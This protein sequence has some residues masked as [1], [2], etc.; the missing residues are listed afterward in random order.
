MGCGASA[1][2][3][4]DHEASDH[5]EL[6]QGTGPITTTPGAP[7]SLSLP[8]TVA[9]AGGI[10]KWNSSNEDL[11]NLTSMLWS[12]CKAKTP[13]EGL[14]EVKAIMSLGHNLWAY[15]YMRM[16]YAKNPEVYYGT[17]LK[18]P[19]LLLPVVYTPTVGEA[20]QKFGKLP[21]QRRGCYV[22]LKDRGNV[23]KVVEEY[24]ASEL[25]KGPDG[26]YMCDC[27]V[28]SDGGR[29][30]GLGDL[31]AW[32][33]GIPIGKLDL[34][35]VC[36]GVNPYRT[37]PVIL[38]AG[39]SDASGNTDKLVIREDP[40]YTGMKQDRVKH[41]SEAKTQVNTA[42]YDNSFVT[43]FMQACCDV[44]GERVLLQFED[45][46]SNDAFP[47]LASHRDKFLTYNDDIQ[48]TAAVA[49]AGLLGGIKLQN[50]SCTD[51]IAEL[52]KKTFLFHGAGSANLGALKLLLE[53]AGVP[54]NQ[55][56]VT[57]S[58][59]V[60]WRNEEGTDGSYRNDEQKEFAQV[61][62]PQYDSTNLVTIIEQIKPNCLVG[63]VGV[64]PNCFDKSVV[65]AM[66]KVNEGGRPCIFAL[67]NPK[68]KAEI[69]AVDCY[70]WSEG[71]AI[72]GS[73]TAFDTV[74]L[75]G[76]KFTPG[77][78]N[79]VYIFPGVSFAAVCCQAKN[80]P[81]RLFMVAA[82]A[83]ANSL[84]SADFGVDRIVPH[85]DRLREVGLNVATAVVAEVQKLGLAGKILGADAAAIKETL[86]TMMW[87]PGKAKE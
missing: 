55:L 70:T 13:D 62:K 23:K 28:F 38:D 54:K 30:L 73:G 72:Y 80:I 43:E 59:G 17:L 2:H 10:D 78:V 61:G 57:N 36:A 68:A 9:N 58:R 56:F 83:V 74:E 29:I 22:A 82:E 75:N 6:R 60:I 87:A 11:K 41:T 85:P 33:M 19:G 48:G 18:E 47:L 25:K 63:A 26:K 12:M 79:N 34:Y 16:L 31:S 51:L 35:T 3:V 64:A 14:K 42:Y 4:N 65:E 39:C 76:K 27:I 5:G 49:V 45:F 53:E 84:D 66:V 8:A 77:Q 44:F 52:R 32:G 81:E 20:C 37:M 24:A 71:K 40:K 21:M 86:K 69:T 1:S 46:N 15:A 67:S 7:R 50:A